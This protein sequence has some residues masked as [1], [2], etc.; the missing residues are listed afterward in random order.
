MTTRLSSILL[1][2]CF[3]FIVFSQ[4]SLQV[5]FYNELENDK[6]MLIIQG[7]ANIDSLSFKPFREYHENYKISTIDYA[8]HES[9]GSGYEIDIELGEI[10]DFD[11]ILVKLDMGS[12][13]NVFLDK[14]S[15]YVR[16]GGKLYLLLNPNLKLHYIDKMEHNINYLISKCYIQDRVKFDQAFIDVKYISGI[17][18]AIQNRGRFE[19][20]EYID[21]SLRRY[22]SSFSIGF[23]I[24]TISD[25]SEA[26]RIYKFSTPEVELITNIFWKVGLGTIGVGTEQ[27]T[28]AYI[29][30]GTL[31]TM[32][33]M[34]LGLGL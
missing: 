25:L 2:F 18:T 27:V 1:L 29:E 5:E 26:Y 16:A 21:L 22:L 31:E 32:L 17:L 6:K 19:Q 12:F 24:K 33:M 9:L 28:S 14:L 3:P 30:K 34:T 10:K 4:D 13:S 23:G 8:S 7:S 15:N 11:L 20:T